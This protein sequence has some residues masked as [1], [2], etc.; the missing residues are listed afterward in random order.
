M[1]LRLDQKIS[2]ILE[3]KIAYNIIE[4]IE[5]SETSYTVGNSN[6]TIPSIDGYTGTNTI[7]GTISELDSNMPVTFKLNSLFI[8]ESSTFTGKIISK[9][10]NLDVNVLLAI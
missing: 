1:Q 4:I 8:M 10:N 2:D 6:I 9:L 7:E 5:W 3:N